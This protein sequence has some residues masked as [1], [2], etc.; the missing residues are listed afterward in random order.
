M[1]ILGDCIDSFNSCCSPRAS[2][3]P[4]KNPSSVPL[5]PKPKGDTVYLRDGRVIASSL[6]THHSSVI[7]HRPSAI[8]HRPS[9]IAHR[10][11]QSSAIAHRP[12]AIAHRPSPI[13]LISRRPS[14][15]DVEC[16][17]RNHSRCRRNKNFEVRRP[18]S[19]SH[20]S[21]VLK[22]HVYISTN[23]SLLHSSAAIGNSNAFI[24][25][26]PALLPAFEA[27]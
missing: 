7:G 24:R 25:R 15:I 21:V 1:N 11:H 14:P 18:P 16:G 19:S 8:A 2:R 17:M 9:P 20:R 6:I 13:A 3:Q 26:T 12:S 27:A 22:K 4:R 5:G 23:A 10:T